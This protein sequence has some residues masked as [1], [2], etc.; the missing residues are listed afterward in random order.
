MISIA[1]QCLSKPFNALSEGH[2]VHA[3]VLGDV[4]AVCLVERQVRQ[5]RTALLAHL[6]VR[7]M[8]FHAQHNELDASKTSQGLLGLKPFGKELKRA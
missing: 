1:F 6:R 8:I 2:R 3:L 4:A 5:G 7:H